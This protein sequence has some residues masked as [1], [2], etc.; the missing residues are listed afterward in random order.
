VVRFSGIYGRQPSALLARLS[1]GR[2]CAKSPARF[3]NRIHREDCVGFLEHLLSLP[4]RE[5]LYLASDSEPVL[6]REMEEWML[7]AMGVDATSEL[8]PRNSADRRC[9][10]RRLLDSGYSLRYPDFRAGY[11]A[12]I[13]STS[14]SADL[15]KAAT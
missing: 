14:M 4:E 15:G 11:R 13:S 3:S 10:N 6:Q 9:C 5:A 8:A 2:L 1:S 12:M 7:A